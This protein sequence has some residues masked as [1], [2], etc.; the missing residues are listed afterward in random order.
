M[1]EA[2]IEDAEDFAE[3][4]NSELEALGSDDRVDGIVLGGEIAR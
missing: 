1:H 2:V 4:L 3:H